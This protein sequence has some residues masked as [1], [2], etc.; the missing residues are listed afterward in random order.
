M[1]QIEKV[2]L[3]LPVEAYHVGSRIMQTVN[4]IFAFLL[5]RLVLHNTAK[6]ILKKSFYLSVSFTLREYIPA[7]ED[8]KMCFHYVFAFLCK[9]QD[10][11]E[12]CEVL[13]Q[14]VLG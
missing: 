1:Q 7:I 9:T 3:H 13:Q 11:P 8:N 14:A 6:R 4:E 12:E 5:R 10:A 2:I